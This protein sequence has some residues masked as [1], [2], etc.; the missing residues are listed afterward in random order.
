MNM[1][2]LDALSRA[3]LQ[4]LAKDV[5]EELQAREQEDRAALAEKLRSLAEDA[6]FDPEDVQFRPARKPKRKAQKHNDGESDD[7]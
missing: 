6:G 5:S 3:Q 4:Q 2:D 7:R 1:P